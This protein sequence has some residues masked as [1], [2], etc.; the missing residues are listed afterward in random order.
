VSVVFKTQVE[1]LVHNHDILVNHPIID[2]FFR[3]TVVMVCGV[4]A[5][6]KGYIWEL[7]VR[8]LCNSLNSKL[9]K[10]ETLEI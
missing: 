1:I 10:I 8:R 7:A 2:L 3:R 5:E 6:I 9:I 4:L